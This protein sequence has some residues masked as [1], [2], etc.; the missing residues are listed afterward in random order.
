MPSLQERLQLMRDHAKALSSGE[1]EVKSLPLL[2]VIK[3]RLLS[4]QNPYNFLFSDLRSGESNGLIV[5]AL[6]VE[7]SMGINGKPHQEGFLVVSYGR[8]PKSNEYS[9]EFMI[10]GEVRPFADKQNF[11]ARFL[12]QKDFFPQL[13]EE[14]KIKILNWTSWAITRKIEGEKQTA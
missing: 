1:R 13:E 5:Q 7:H 8:E 3:K 14:T 9:M 2:E 12:R 4:I 10:Y 11:F 6:D